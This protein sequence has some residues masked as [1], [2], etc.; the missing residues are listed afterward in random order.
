MTMQER[1][2]TALA[3]GQLGR[4]D[5]VELTNLDDRQVDVALQKMRQQGLVAS[6]GFS[7]RA[8]WLRVPGAMY[9]GDRRGLGP[10]SRANLAWEVKRTGRKPPSLDWAALIP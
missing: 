3:R 6:T 10:R 8:K 4:S 9:P 1:V 5:L 7:H 2:W